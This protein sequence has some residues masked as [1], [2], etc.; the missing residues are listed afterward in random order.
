LVI[1]F[2]FICISITPSVAVDIVQ[3]SSILISDKTGASDDYK[4]IITIINADV[5]EVKGKGRA[6]IWRDVEI[7]ARS[8][9]PFEIWGIKQPNGNGLFFREK[10]EYLKAPLIIGL[11]FSQPP[12]FASA[13]GV[14]FGNIEWS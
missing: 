8:G 13:N 9:E 3:E 7:I 10:I 5:W 1:I 14:A 4:E 12:N 2:L 6:F 11:I